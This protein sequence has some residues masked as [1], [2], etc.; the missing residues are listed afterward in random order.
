[1]KINKIFFVIVTIILASVSAFAQQQGVNVNQTANAGTSAT[2]GSAVIYIEPITGT[3]TVRQPVYGKPKNAPKPKGY[4]NKQITV[5]NGYAGRIEFDIPQQNNAVNQSSVVVNNQL[6]DDLSKRVKGTEDGVKFLADELGKTNGNLNELKNFTVTNIQAL[7]A[8]DQALLQRL[9]AE[10]NKP[11]KT[12]SL[13][14]WIN[15]GLIAGNYLLDFL[16]G[17]GSNNS[18]GGNWNGG[19]GNNCDRRTKNCYNTGVGG[20]CTDRGGNCNYNNNGGSGPRSIRN[21]SGSG[22]GN[23]GRTEGTNSGSNSG[24]SIL[25]GCGN[26]NSSS[27][28]SS[29]YN[30]GGAGGNVITGGRRYN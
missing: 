16:R 17:R 23:F 18:N 30:G 6:V 29:S 28:T 27:G 12:G 4:V 10:E 11:D 9:I 22:N 2:K 25:M 7:N 14:Q 20:N 5:N 1:M 15:T 26:R 19:G 24:C 21:G 13:H 3:K 8:N